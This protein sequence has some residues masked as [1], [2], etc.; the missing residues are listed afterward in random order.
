MN[1]KSILFLSGT[2][3][4]FGKIKSLLRVLADDS[5]F[6]IQIFVTGMHLSKKYGYTI[7]EIY[8]EGYKNIYPF[9]NQASNERME[10]AL[11]KTIIGISNY[12]QEHPID[13]IVVHGDRVETL[14]GAISCSLNNILVGHIEGGELSGT[15]DESIRHA[16]SKLSHLH[17][18][19]NKDSKSRLI[20]LGEDKNNI[21][22]IGSPD[23]DLMNPKK[24]PSLKK[25]KNNY[26]INFTKY[27][28]GM[29]HPVTTELENT[30]KYIC[31]YLNAL[32]K[33]GK[34][35]ILVYP[36][37]DL[38]SKIIIDYLNKAEYEGFK[39]F[40][41]IR[42]EYFLRLLY[43]C[44]FII[45]NS[46]AGIREAPFYG[47]PTINIGS[48][49]NRRSNLE[50]IINCNYEEETILKAIKSL[51]QI[52]NIRKH[53][54]IKFGSGDSDKRFLKILSNKKIWNT[55]LQKF[56]CDIEP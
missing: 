55:N 37:N 18:V 11:A 29:F 27:A 52:S 32:R 40:P 25:V 46:S 33:S 44:E 36:N 12:I 53:K 28:I 49:Q 3:A 56:F 38:G 48:R 10:E 20:Q 4:D 5:N 51:N 34:K 45:G 8:K 23:L 31:N 42:F 35:Y 30:E 24:L 7:D 13:M 39:I 2:R 43:Q 21:F 41:S 22:V 16:V 15:I 9:I 1:K 19:S 14:A 17:F 54:S 6:D 26:N 50:S 47:V